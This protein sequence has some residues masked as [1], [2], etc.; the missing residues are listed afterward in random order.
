MRKPKHHRNIN[1][2]TY[3]TGGKKT[4]GLKFQGE[5]MTCAICGKQEQSDPAVE[6]NWRYIEAD[7]KGGYVCTD[8]FPP[9]GASEGEFSKAYQAA[10]LAVIGK[11][12]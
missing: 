11:T 9:D 8:H 7:G 4:P 6:K 1:K 5:L 2:V 12:Q 10:I 3:L